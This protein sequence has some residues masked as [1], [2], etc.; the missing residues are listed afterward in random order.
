MENI[1]DKINLYM[2]LKISIILVI[3]I[4]GL[5]LL[6]YLIKK[7]L[8]KTVSIHT[9]KLLQKAIFWVGTIIILFTILDQ[10][11]IKLTALISAL[12]IAG[13]AIGFASQT[14]VS[15]IISGI[16]LI[17]ERTF[18][19]GDLVKVGDK[20]GKVTSIDLLSIKLK[21]FD[22]QMVRI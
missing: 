19:I 13:V 16:F 22:N 7:F 9:R 5:K 6:I 10:L 17:T 3:G 14:S 8:K 4:A 21:T 11:G 2:I 15:N 18:E 12:G 20:L 1:I